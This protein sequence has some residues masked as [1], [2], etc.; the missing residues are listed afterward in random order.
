MSFLKIILLVTIY[1]YLSTN[2][3]VEK[4]YEFENVFIE[5]GSLSSDNHIDG[6]IKIYD[7]ETNDLKDEIIYDTGGYDLFKYMAI[8]GEGEFVIV[9]DTYYF[10]LDYKYPIYRNS[11]LL[12]YNTLGDLLL[13]KPIDFRPSNYYNHN[14]LLILINNNEEI[15]YNQD[16]DIL[17]NIEIA[18]EVV[19]DFAYQ[20]QGK[21]MV[22][23]TEVEDILI[24]YPG[25]YEITII[26]GEYNFS[27]N[28]TV[29]PDIKITGEDYPNGYLGSVI[30]Y[31][32]G[33]LFLNNDRYEMGTEI[34]Q[35]GNY[36]LV[37]I[38]MNNYSSH[39]NF[40]ILPDVVCN[41]GDYNQERLIEGQVF[42]EPIQIY[43]NA[44]SM[45]LNGGIYGSDLIDYPGL[46]SLTLYGVNSFEVTISFLLKPSVSGVEDGRTYNEVDLR[47]F[48]EALL[49]GKKI[50]GSQLI[51]KDGEY[52]L[53]LL[54]DDEVIQSIKF[55]IK[56]NETENSE[57]I[58]EFLSY[59]KYVFLFITL[60][61]GVVI[62]RKK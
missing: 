30:I 4:V 8:V 43:S 59:L 26:D 53:E 2:Y 50:S 40:T 22:N 27:F 32:L 45:F 10:N 5:F 34:S 17:D 42:Y 15:I 7:K 52:L 41:Y 11:I 19:G 33:E 21:A 39:L 12:K 51:D 62:L 16:L 20:F 1:F 25:I 38:G 60:I 13:E 61:G 57:N 23:G 54:L 9:C 37:I 47:L 36:D 24:Y 55:T 28:V 58:R 14:N 18:N 31:G 48:G 29:H 56:R 49:N 35:V 3:N 46:Y 6:Y 44:Q